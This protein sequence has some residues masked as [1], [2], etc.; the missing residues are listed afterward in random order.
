LLL[1][2]GNGQARLGNSGNR[3]LKKVV[4]RTDDAQAIHLGPVTHGQRTLKSLQLLFFLIGE[5]CPSTRFISTM[6][7]VIQTVTLL[8]SGN[9]MVVGGL[10][11]AASLL[12][13][14][15]R[16]YGSRRQTYDTRL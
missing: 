11:L 7:R 4:S 5:R 10:R 16:P 6:F 9:G 3:T 2:L 13:S 12:F 1:M 15:S 14:I 8:P